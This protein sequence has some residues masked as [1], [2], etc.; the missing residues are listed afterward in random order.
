MGAAIAME[1]ALVV[2]GLVEAAAT[3]DEAAIVVECGGGSSSVR[4]QKWRIGGGSNNVRQQQWRTSGG[5]LSS[6]GGMWWRQQQHE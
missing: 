4:Q 1:Q 5:R 6:S 2:E 3:M